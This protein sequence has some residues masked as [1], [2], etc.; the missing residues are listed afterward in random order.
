MSI[1]CPGQ[2]AVQSPE[3][4][5]TGEAS[6]FARISDSIICDLFRIIMQDL[7]VMPTLTW[8]RNNT[9]IC[10]EKKPETQT[11]VWLGTVKHF[12]SALPTPSLWLSEVFF[13]FPL[14]SG[15]PTKLFSF[16]LFGQSPLDLRHGQRDDHKRDSAWGDSVQRDQHEHPPD[17]D[18]GR[19]P[20]GSNGPEAAGKWGNVCPMPFMLV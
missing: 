2:A 16:L 6:V 19:V 11:K 13:L 4:I 8:T 3:S 14:S 1:K 20:F 15:P 7:L 9:Q 12:I 5:R 17:H 10:T 18:Q